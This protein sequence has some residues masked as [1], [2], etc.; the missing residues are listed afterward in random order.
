MNNISES[1][2]F[3][4]QDHAWLSKLL[5]GGLYVFLSCLLIG[6]PVL[7][8]YYI[9]LL[10]RVRRNEPSP[11]PE[12]KEPGVKFIVGIKFLV[13]LFLYYIPL[14]VIIVPMMVFIIAASFFG[15]DSMEMIE[16]ST[17]LTAILLTALPY[18]LFVY[19]L[20][21]L[22]AMQFAERESIRDGLRLGRVFTL[23]KLY[24]QE[25]VIIAMIS[26]G[27]GLLSALG[28]I[29]FIVGI[30][31]TVFYTTVV[32]FHLYGRLARLADESSFP[33]VTTT[34]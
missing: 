7:F 6:L 15:S 8:G 1:F 9:E 16:G 32:R 21:P 29:A 33:P 24:W 23:F 5:L 4:F 19:L 14:L 30:L 3:P 22:I 11:L 27:I 12:W 13:T 20:I 28:F 10:Q 17:L 25:A 18:A 2:T 31:F 26:I 34:P